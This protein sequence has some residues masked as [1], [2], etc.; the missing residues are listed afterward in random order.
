MILE[1]EVN[2]KLVR[3]EILQEGYNILDSKAFF[4]NSSHSMVDKFIVVE[5][6]KRGYLNTFISLRVIHDRH[7]VFEQEDLFFSN[8]LEELIEVLL[9]KYKN[10]MQFEICQVLSDYLN[11]I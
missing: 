5:K 9:L 7:K 1:R 3:L 2:E 6:L 4:I 10:K 8:S 11:N